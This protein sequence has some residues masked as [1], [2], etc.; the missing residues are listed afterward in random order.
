MFIRKRKNRSGSTSIVVISRRHGQFVEVRNF[1]TA[2]SEEDVS[3]LYV[4]ATSSLS[5]VMI[6]LGNV[7]TYLTILS[8]VGINPSPMCL[9]HLLVT[10]NMVK[11]TILA[12]CGSGLLE[13][14]RNIGLDA[15]FTNV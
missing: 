6:N 1:G 8:L 12:E 13:M 9:A 10:G 3:R 7:I 4:Q 2:E 14:K 11:S 5:M 15:L